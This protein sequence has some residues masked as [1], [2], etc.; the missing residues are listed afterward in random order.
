MKNNFISFIFE[1]LIEEFINTPVK[2]MGNFGDFLAEKIG[3]D[4][5]VRLLAHFYMFILF[6]NRLYTK[7]LYEKNKILHLCREIKKI[8]KFLFL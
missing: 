2:R 7:K 3:K 4:K 8:F 5:S 6:S 1:V